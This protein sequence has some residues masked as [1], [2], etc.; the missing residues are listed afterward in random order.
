M[1][2]LRATGLR[3][4]LSQLLQIPSTIVPSET[5][6][7]RATTSMENLPL[8]SAPGVSDMACPA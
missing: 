6:F 8:R 1:N 3:H 7:R 4:N 2:F 5:A